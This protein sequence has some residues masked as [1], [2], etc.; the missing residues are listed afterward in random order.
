[1]WRKALFFL[2]TITGVRAAAPCY[3]KLNY[4]FPFEEVCYQTIFNGTNGL[5]LR[6]YSGASLE[7]TLVT[8]NASASITTYQEALTLTTF[9]I[10]EYLIGGGNVQN[11]SL[12]EA[13]TVP[14]V[15]RPPT[16]DNND[17]LAFMALA[18]SKFPPKSHPPSPVPSY[19][20][21]LKPFGN[22]GSTPVT[23]AVQRADLTQDPQPSDFDDLCKK[24][25]SGIKSQLPTWKIDAA[26]PYTYSHARYYTEIF[27]G[28]YWT[29]E[30]VAEVVKA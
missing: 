18:P 5:S 23:L 10:I 20:V 14:L 1:M 17:W 3:G 27:F 4:T 21:V 26:S 25:E 6:E 16:T 19:G 30:C 24:I 2:S 9:Y 28:S 22:K 29:C 12:L 7:A 8:Y 15:L 13:R 11:K